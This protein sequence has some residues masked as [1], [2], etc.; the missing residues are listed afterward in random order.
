MQTRTTPPDEPDV[1]GDGGIIEREVETVRTRQHVAGAAVDAILAP[2]TVAIE[3]SVG[4]F[5]TQRL[6][7]VGLVARWAI[8]ALLGIRFLLHAAGANTSSAFVGF[9]DAVSWP[10]AGPFANVFS[11]RS[12]G[13]GGIEVSTLVAM[14]VYFL[15]FRLLGMLVSALAPRLSGVAARRRVTA[16]WSPMPLS[17]TTPDERHQ[18]PRPV[19]ATAVVRRH[20]RL[21]RRARAREA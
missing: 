9:V 6:S 16:P 11:N 5:E 17:A 14:G 4:Y 12:L 18:R 7:A 13:S 8:E 15:I 10:L 21:L 2:E 3:Q 20:R 1:T 19:V